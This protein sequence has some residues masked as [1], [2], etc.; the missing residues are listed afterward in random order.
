MDHPL[1]VA[2]ADADLHDLAHLCDLLRHLGHEVVAEAS[3]GPELVER[4]RAAR[5]DLVLTEV[6]LAGLDGLA[7]AEEIDGEREV[8]V[9]IVSARED[10]ELLERAAA[11][12]VASYLVKP[13]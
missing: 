11:G 13:V 8:R 10:D 3:G 1:R 4:C 12:S 5:P 2:V 6:T 9:V 7:A